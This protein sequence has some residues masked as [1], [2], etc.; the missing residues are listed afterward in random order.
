MPALEGMGA[1]DKLEE[2]VG[3]T[4]AAVGPNC[5]CLFHRCCLHGHIRRPVDALHSTRP[6]LHLGTDPGYWA[7]MPWTCTYVMLMVA[8]PFSNAEHRLKFSSWNAA[9]W[10]AQASAVLWV[11]SS[12]A[13]LNRSMLLTKPWF[14]APV[15]SYRLLTWA[16]TKKAMFVGPKE[17]VDA[18]VRTYVEHKALTSYDLL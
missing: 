14:E 16:R 7:P 2:H 13:L 5:R 11:K 18:H 17:V 1:V 3:L 12:S 6:L 15:P 10:C 9:A 4:A 8:S